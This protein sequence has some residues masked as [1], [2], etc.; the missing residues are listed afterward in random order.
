MGQP[1]TVEK[2]TSVGRVY[3]QL[4]LMAMTY[5]FRPGERINEAELSKH[6]D[7]SRTPLR[8]ALN[9]L[10][11]EGYVAAVPNRGFVGRLLDVSEILALYEFR[12]ALEQAIMRLVCERATDEELEALVGFARHSAEIE[13]P[14]TV[15]T[16][17]QDEEF[18][19]RIARLT[20]NAEFVRALEN[21][22]G[23]IHFVRWIDLRQRGR[24]K[25]AH[26]Q[27]ARLLQSRDAEKCVAH[28]GKVIRRRNDEIID[29][30]R[31]GTADI[32][33]GPLAV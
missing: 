20:R 25:K 1:H 6:L 21:V 30:I 19:M 31:T 17:Q 10:A 15:E 16:L 18:H 2:Q 14:P 8:E 28:I 33:L 27:I 23:R 29:V 26:L 32:F 7:V 9:R 12:C 24:S 3:D 22:N 11:S 5:R 13:A 4:R